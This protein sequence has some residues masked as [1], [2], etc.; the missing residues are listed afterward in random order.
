MTVGVSVSLNVDQ[1]DIVEIGARANDG[2]N[3][4]EFE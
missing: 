1:M 4:V 2:V 3:G